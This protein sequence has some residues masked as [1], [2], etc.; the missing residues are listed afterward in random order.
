MSGTSLT[1]T[2]GTAS[3]STIGAGS[4]GT[5][6]WRPEPGPFDRAAN[7]VDLSAV[8]EPGPADREF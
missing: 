2:L 3:G 7:A 6:T 1:I 4:Q 8:T 5:V